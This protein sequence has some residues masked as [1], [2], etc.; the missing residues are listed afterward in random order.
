MGVGEGTSVTE[1][2]E[3]LS[4]SVKVKR[5]QR[6]YDMM[7]EGEWREVCDEFQGEDEYRETLL[8]W[9]R[10][11]Q[12]D[13]F[14]QIFLDFFNYDQENFQECLQWIGTKLQQLS[15]SSVSR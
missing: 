10:P 7:R 12:V 15:I 5:M 1:V 11:S 13:R 8:L 9:V 6:V 4:H 2:N 14:L 3:E